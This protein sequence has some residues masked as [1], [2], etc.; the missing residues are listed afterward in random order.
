VSYS[1]GQVAE[2]A[3]VTVRTLHHYDEIGLL[4]PRDRSGAG[5]RRYAESDLERLQQIM[6]YRELGFAL[7]EITVML[8]DPEADAPE[9]LRRQHELL[10][11]R[12]KRIDA[13]VEAVER[14]M[15][16]HKM[17][18]SLTPEER[19]EVFGEHDPA[20]YADEAR[21]RWGDSDPYRQSQSR[22][23][24]YTKADWLAIKAEAADIT[25]AFAD[26]MRQGHPATSVTAMDLAERHRQ[27][28]TR[29]FYECPPQ[30]HQG[31]ASLYITD[32]RFA[33]PYDHVAAGLAQY[34]HDAVQA[35]AARPA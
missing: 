20:Q 19:F 11:E 28:I 33:A 34:I 27:H 7:D 8:D 2:L 22:T 31:L 13:M 25:G 23:R 16:A 35:N 4:R 1:V 32:D 17:G 15:E 14:A 10:T 30:L 6:F 21:E 24:G 26:A 12:R 3:G 29:W 5:Y 18:I 9:H